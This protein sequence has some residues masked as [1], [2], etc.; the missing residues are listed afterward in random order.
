MVGVVERRGKIEREAEKNKIIFVTSTDV[1]APHGRIVRVLKSTCERISWKKPIVK[2]GDDFSAKK[3]LF[4]PAGI[5]LPNCN[6]RRW[7]SPFRPL[8]QIRFEN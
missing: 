7:V 6:E 1:D 8:Y 3:V 5:H 2:I 4:L